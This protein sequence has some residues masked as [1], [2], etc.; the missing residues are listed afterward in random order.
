MKWLRYFVLLLP[1]LLAF[2]F[3]FALEKCQYKKGDDECQSAGQ[4]LADGGV[5]HNCWTYGGA[6]CSLTKFRACKAA[7]FKPATNSQGNCL[8]YPPDPNGGIPKQMF[9]I[10]YN[11]EDPIKDCPYD[12]DYDPDDPCG[13]GKDPATCDMDDPPPDDPDDPCGN[14]KDPET[15]DIDDDPDNPP[16]PDIPI[17]D[18]DYKP[19]APPCQIMVNG[20]CVYDD[21]NRKDKI[22]N[23]EGV[24]KCFEKQANGI[25]KEVPCNSIISYDDDPCGNG[26]DPA[27]CDD[28]TADDPPDSSTDK[29]YNPNSEYDDATYNFD[30][31]DTS[32]KLPDA[33]DI[34]DK[35]REV[36]LSSW[37]VN[38]YFNSSGQCPAPNT[39]SLGMFG[40]F[41]V[42]Y[43]YF[44]SIARILRTVVIA[45]SWLTGL[46]IIAKINK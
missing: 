2:E 12:P 36:D 18:D 39:V 41:E 13:N 45:F 44:C 9:K 27:T 22:C 1:L 20:K 17:Y 11:G 32:T 46:L 28:S 16:K 8:A 42:S 37:G 4:V 40:S 21:P 25:L 10:F 7:G 6:G 30:D 19:D 15:C 3:S 14:G 5:C 38:D 43:E 31:L 33:K 23:A 34:K 29:S 24:C 35:T 26:K